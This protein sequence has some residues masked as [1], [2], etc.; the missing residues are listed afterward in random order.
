MKT[1]YSSHL[2]EASLPGAI[3]DLETTL[4]TVPAR[5]E[6]LPDVMVAEAR[7]IG[8]WS[9]K[10]IIGHLIDS[11]VNNHQRFVR[12]QIE[13]HLD[14]GVLRSP[15]YA[16]E[17]WVRVGAYQDRDWRELVQLWAVFNRQVLHV[18]KHADVPSLQTPVS[19]NGKE[20]V[21]LELVMIDYVGH[22]K[23][24]LAQVLE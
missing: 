20:P 14:A 2:S 9:P 7:A 3:R 21:T 24:H 15:G 6:A 5:L 22:V 12:A 16:Q 4:N 18:I 1:H 23:H 19:V 17:D 8:K 13:A 10:Q 11:A